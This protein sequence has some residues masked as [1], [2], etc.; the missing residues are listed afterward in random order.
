MQLTDE[1][2]TGILSQRRRL[3][4]PRLEARPLGAAL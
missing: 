2:G 4:C 3:G 1:Q